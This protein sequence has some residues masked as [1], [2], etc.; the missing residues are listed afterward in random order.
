ME[1]TLPRLWTVQDVSLWLSC[2]ARQV[3]RWAKAGK[4]PSIALPDGELMFDPV[5]LTKWLARQRAEGTAD[6]AK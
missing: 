2:P 3:I 6:V 5:E 1:P 4:L